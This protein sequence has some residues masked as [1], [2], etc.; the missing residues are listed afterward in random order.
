MSA[1]LDENN[2][3]MMFPG[4]PHA[5]PH[6]TPVPANAP[7]Y[8]ITHCFV[9]FSLLDAAMLQISTEQYPSGDGMVKNRSPLTLKLVTA[10]DNQVLDPDYGLNPGQKSGSGSGTKRNPVDPRLISLARLLAR[11]AAQDALDSISQP[12]NDNDIDKDV[13]P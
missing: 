10:N 3:Q 9:C 4:I 7:Q 1:L 5:S 13:T 8:S 11:S 6:D 2:M 12:A